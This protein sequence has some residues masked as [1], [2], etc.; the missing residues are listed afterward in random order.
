MHALGAGEQP[1]KGRA[2]ELWV[3]YVLWSLDTVSGGRE[4]FRASRSPWVASTQSPPPEATGSHILDH[5][6]PRAT[7]TTRPSAPRRPSAGH[8]SSAQGPC[9]VQRMSGVAGT[10]RRSAAGD[11]QPLPVGVCGCFSD[12]V[13][14]CCSPRCPVTPRPPQ[15]ITLPRRI[16]QGLSWPHSPSSCPCGGHHCLTVRTRGSSM[17][18][19]QPLRSGDGPWQWAPVTGQRGPVISQLPPILRASLQVDLSRPAWAWPLELPPSK[20]ASCLTV[21]QAPKT[22]QA[23]RVS[24]GV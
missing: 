11:I 17:W 3:S 1:R 12:D 19:S 16:Q 21:S 14:P 7:P 20:A 6:A 10:G 4:V 22:R 2:H 23:A 24:S 18:V 9:G 13:P 15:P 8:L 5:P